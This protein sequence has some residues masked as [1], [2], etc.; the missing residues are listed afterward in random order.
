MATTVQT[1]Q[2]AQGAQLGGMH[3]RRSNHCHLQLFYQDPKPDSSLH[4]HGRMYK[5]QHVIAF[6]RPGN[7]AHPRYLQVQ[8]EARNLYQT[9]I[10]SP[11]QRRNR[12]Y[13]LSQ[14]A[15]KSTIAGDSRHQ[16]QERANDQG[17]AERSDGGTTGAGLLQQTKRQGVQTSVRHGCAYG[18]ATVGRSS[19]EDDR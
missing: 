8:L 14:R 13:E 18:I 11:G 4:R 9:Q 3:Q 12:L 15:I 19:L 2:A 16:N 5:V 1:A 7:P 6:G 17:N 10:P